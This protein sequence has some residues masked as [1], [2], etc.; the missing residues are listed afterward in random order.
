MCNACGFRCCGY[1]GFSKCGCDWCEE[2]ECWDY[3]DLDETD[4]EYPDYDPS[5]QGCCSK[6]SGFAC[7]EV[8]P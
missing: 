7:E 1:D 6:L 3:D 2:P 8:K 4:D 5:Y